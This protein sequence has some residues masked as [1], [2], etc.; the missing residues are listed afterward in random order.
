MSQHNWISSKFI[1]S[2]NQKYFCY[3]YQKP[4]LSMQMN[5]CK[6]NWGVNL[7]HVGFSS[8]AGERNLCMLSPSRKPVTS[9]F[10]QGKN[11]HSGKYC[12][13]ADALQHTLCFLSLSVLCA[14]VHYST[15]SPSAMRYP[16][17]QPE[18]PFMVKIH[19]RN[20]MPCN[21]LRRNTHS[22]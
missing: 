21:N 17:N 18:L 3:K 5:Y 10:L 22:F 6:V 11:M 2:E 15:L 4:G 1:S 12:R 16:N 13:V 14:H 20:H 8:V 19:H 9:G 7:Q